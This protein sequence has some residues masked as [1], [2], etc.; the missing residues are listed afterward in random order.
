MYFDE[1][2]ISISRELGLC[3]EAVRSCKR[4]LAGM[5]SRHGMSTEV[6]LDRLQQ[7]TLCASR[8][9]RKWRDGVEGLRRWSAARNEYERLLQIMK[10]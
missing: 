8:E 4:L 6:F 9:F 7:G 1:Y 5:E 10:S 3:N 2:G